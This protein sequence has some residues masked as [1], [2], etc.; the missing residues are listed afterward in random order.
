MM[1][2]SLACVHAETAAVVELL[3][4]VRRPARAFCHSIWI[5][6]GSASHHMPAIQVPHMLHTAQST[7]PL[8]PHN[9]HANQGKFDSTAL[10]SSPLH[11]RTDGM[12][13]AHQL[14]CAAGS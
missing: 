3:P 13:L 11:S 9:E 4:M 8:C 7:L 14:I 1:L 6:S 5:S 10:G 12:C 2:V